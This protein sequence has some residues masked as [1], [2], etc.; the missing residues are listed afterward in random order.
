MSKTKYTKAMELFNKIRTISSSIIIKN[1][2]FSLP[3]FSEKTNSFQSFFPSLKYSTRLIYIDPGLN[4]TITV[5]SPLNYLLNH[6]WC[7]LMH[8][9]LILTYHKLDIIALRH[10]IL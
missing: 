5:G 2:A 9:S 7:L 4:C 1:I 6:A 10:N 8:D 3:R